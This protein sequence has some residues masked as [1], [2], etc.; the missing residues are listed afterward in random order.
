MENELYQIMFLLSNG[1]PLLFV[2]Y[3]R[4]C[5]LD[6]MQVWV[7]KN[8]GWDNLVDIS[9]MI[10]SNAFLSA[11]WCT[12]IK[13]SMECAPMSLFGNKSALDQVKAMHRQARS[14]CMNKCWHKPQRVK[15][16]QPKVKSNVYCEIFLPIS[17]WPNW[18]IEA[19]CMINKTSSQV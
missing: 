1:I 2:S 4:V 7:N 14:Y 13:I 16:N 10:F 12:V 17:Q 9:P 6:S 8:W 5:T 3:I 15:K 18:R 19:T 11:N